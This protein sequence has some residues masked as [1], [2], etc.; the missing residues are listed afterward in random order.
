MKVGD[1][2]RL[3]DYPK[4]PIG[5]IVSIERRG[6]FRDRWLAKV[7]WLEHDAY[8]QHRYLKNLEVVSE[9]R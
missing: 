4:A 5:L 6:V 8:I 2:V 9:S 3:K 7:Q 1:L